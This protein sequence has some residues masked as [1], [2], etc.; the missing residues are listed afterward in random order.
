VKDRWGAGVLEGREKS[1][2]RK[3][4]EEAEGVGRDKCQIK[5]IRT[6]RRKQE[7]GGMGRTICGIVVT[8]TVWEDCRVW[9]QP[10]S[11]RARKRPL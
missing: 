7:A 2:G 5:L 8:V 3:S 10:G 4:K 9:G 11:L 1:G 6:C